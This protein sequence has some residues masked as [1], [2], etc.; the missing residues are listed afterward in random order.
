MRFS[1]PL[2]VIHCFFILTTPAHVLEQVAMSVF[3]DFKL[4]SKFNIDPSVFQKWICAVQ[5]AYFDN[6]YAAYLFFDYLQCSYHNSVHAADVT[7]ALYYLIRA[8]GAEKFKDI[9]LLAAT[10]AAIV[11]DLRHPGVNN[12]CKITKC[13]CLIILSPDSNNR[14]SVNSL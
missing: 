1:F 4:F 9:D 12:N 3:E 8:H 11:H 2:V 10:Y 7:Q 14:L 13:C 6:P 5:T